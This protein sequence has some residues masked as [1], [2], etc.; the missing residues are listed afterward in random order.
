MSG[1]YPGIPLGQPPSTRPDVIRHLP[2]LVGAISVIGLI[3]TL[4]PMWSLNLAPRDFG[5]ERSQLDIDDDGNFTVETIS[6]LATVKFGFY[7]WI[8]AAAPA[9]GLI[10]VV[11]AVTIATVVAQSLRRGASTMWAAVSA[12][13]LCAIVVVSTTALRPQTRHS[14][15]G[16][17]ALELDDGNGLT[18]LNQPPSMDAQIGAGLVIAVVALVAVCGLTGWQYLVD[19][20]QP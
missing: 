14:I 17:L 10:P 9:A 11:F 20:K 13:S 4:F 3:G 2:W 6:G 5:F 16:P 8:L 18:S 15:T 19:R 1:P 7:D 12:F